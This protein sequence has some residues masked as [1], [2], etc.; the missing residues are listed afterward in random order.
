MDK[1]EV[2]LGS[3]PAEVAGAE[4]WML[5][6]TTVREIMV[7]VG[8]GEG[9]KRIARKLGVDR[10]TVRRWARLGCWQPRQHR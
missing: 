6:E 5:D 9:F 8:R 1:R 2:W 7:R 4:G 10:N 3:P